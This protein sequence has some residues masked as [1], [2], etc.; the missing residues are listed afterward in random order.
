M[1][2]RRRNEGSQ[3]DPAGVSL[4]PRP[5]RVDE[6]P[7]GEVAGELA[8]PGQPRNR[9]SSPTSLRKDT[10][11]PMR[12]AVGKRTTEVTESDGQAKRSKTDRRARVG[13][14]AGSSRSGNL[15]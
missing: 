11:L 1:K 10:Q 5:G 14:R 15:S 2:I 8:L 13:E 3:R 9:D 12:I 6:L 4:E 7:P